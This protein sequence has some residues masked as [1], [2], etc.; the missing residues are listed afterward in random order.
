MADFP[1]QVKLNEKNI[2]ELVA[3]YKKAYK[4]IVQEISTATDFGI[5]NR[6]AILRQIDK[7]LV[8]LGVDTQK[9]LEKELP[10][11]YKTG[12]GHAVSQ[13]EHIDAPVRVGTGFS[14]VHKQAIVALIDETS[15]AFAEG[16]TGV[17][18]SASVVLNKAV[19]EEMKYRLAAGQ[20]KGEALVKTKQTITG[21]LQEQGL[22]ALKTR[23]YTN[24]AGTVIQRTI[25]LDDYAEMLIRTKAVEARNTGLVNRMVENDYDLVQVSAH[26]ATD[27]CGDWEGEILS[28]TGET[29]GYKTVS[30]AE[31]SGL[32]HPNCR[33]SI[34]VIQPDLAKETMA[35]NPDT[36]EYEKGLL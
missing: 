1:A 35:W 21:L 17:K 29:S 2:S 11:Y 16:L 20:L 12:A 8:E 32:F 26:G 34:N 14:V 31:S 28:L 18:R 3:L 4:E 33:H 24:K 30:D 23:A 19:K 5:A 6:K 7:T 25:K 36:Q 15:K 13:L 27:V 10:E 22:S 9:F